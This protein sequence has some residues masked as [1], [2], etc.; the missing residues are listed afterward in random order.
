MKKIGLLGLMICL[1]LAGCGRSGQGENASI[2]QGAESGPGMI[3]SAGE[4]VPGAAP[5]HVKEVETMR[6][7]ELEEGYTQ[8]SV[9]YRILGKKI[10]MLRVENTEEKAG[11]RL[12]VQIYDAD[13]SKIRQLFIVPEIPQREN[14]SIVS[15]DLT[16]GMELSLKLRD[17][18]ADN[19]FFLVRMNL[20]G[21]VLKLVEPFPEEEFYPWNTEFV[22]NLHTYALSDGRT[23][24]G[25][26]DTQEQT[27]ALTWF[28]EDTETEEPL[29]TIDC[30]S[31]NSLMLDEDGTFYY[32]DGARL[33]RWDLANNTQEDLF[34]L[35]EN[36]IDLSGTKG[37]MRNKDGELLLCCLQQEKGTIYVLTDKE[38]TGKEKIRLCSLL[39]DSGVMYFQRLAATFTQ[40]GGALPISMSME[41][42]AE[43]QEDYR[44]R[45]LA[46]MMA[47]AG[48]DILYVSREDMILMQEKG[49][50]CDL[51]DMIAQETQEVL[52]PGVLKLGTVNGELVGLVPETSFITL[53]TGNAVWGEDGWNTE[54]LIGVMKADGSWEHPFLEWGVDLSGT[55]IF[56]AI[57]FMDPSAAN[58]ILDLEHGQAH[59]DRQEFIEILELCKKYGDQR[60]Y[61][62]KRKEQLSLE[63]C[64]ALI[65]S[66]EVVAEIQRLYGGLD[67]FSTLSERYGDQAHIV[68]F[69]VESGSGCYVDSYSYGYLVVNANTKYK[70]EISK[71]FA[72]LLDYDNQFKT[73]GGCVRMDVIRDSVAYDEWMDTY[74]MLRSSSE[75][76]PHYQPIALKPDGTAYLEEYLAFVEGCE[77]QP[78]WP[79]QIHAIIVEELI[80]FYN[81]D[82]SAEEAADIIQRRVQLYLDETR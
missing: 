63:E 56:F 60:T 52:I 42:K 61:E 64:A 23:I 2:P 3:P 36:G 44:T 4:I 39:G 54:E 58:T 20:D 51:S 15:A 68:G 48:P 30:G 10:Y 6:F 13:T 69:P 81:G 1:L 9:H 17:W 62:E 21:D 29:A 45:I 19:S 7:Q 77:P 43:Y 46:E 57:L 59:F 49:M 14:S 65:R 55:S 22:E 26:S 12:N 34:H 38:E 66:G 24:L 71:F 75:E 72:Q 25:R 79:E 82:K 18:D 11:A 35:Y 37:L 70:E 40:N 41:N 33:I 28:Q 53:G 5:L 74:Y 73:S 50:I 32:L 47:A 31:V 80:P 78:Y 27:T 8:H 76:N 67:A 16:A